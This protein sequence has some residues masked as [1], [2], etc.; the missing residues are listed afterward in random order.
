M[1]LWIIANIV[2]VGFVA[3][4]LGGLLG[5]GGSVI[6][7]PCL[8]LL[9]GQGDTYNQH[10]YQAAA[11]IANVLI[12]LPASIRHYR[13]GA[14]IPAALRRIFPFALIAIFVGVW[15]SNQPLF[16]GR[17]GA[18]LLGRCLALFIAYVI[19][20]NVR[21]LFSSRQSPESESGVPSEINVPRAGFVGTVMGFVAGLMG[22]GGGA[23]A[24][25]LQQIL[26]KFP[27]KSCIANSSA[28]ICM[29][30]TV[31]AVYKNATLP[32]HNLS[33]YHSLLIAAMLAPTA[34]IGGYLGANLTHVLP[35]RTV[36]IAFI[37]LM[38]IACWRL[39]AL[40]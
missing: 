8:V 4:T 14:V 26:L 16:H 17:E 22:I 7:I 24:V 35:V 40:G 6:M 2:V 23:I 37:A 18:V 28:I 20:V 31:G 21:K 11:M 10:L 30:S 5:V 38:L 34:T 15:S 27:L 25:P 29:T 12:S 13:S 33:I 9:L 39:A 36:R 19:Y 3:G 1:E 32:F